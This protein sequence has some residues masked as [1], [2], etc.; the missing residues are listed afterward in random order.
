ML[1]DSSYKRQVPM[2]HVTYRLTGF[3]K[4]KIYQQVSILEALP[5][6]VSDQQVFFQVLEQPNSLLYVLK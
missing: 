1:Y 2:L 5:Q 6:T 4:L 3:I